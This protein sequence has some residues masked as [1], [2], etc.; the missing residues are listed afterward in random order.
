[1]TKETVVYVTTIEEWK[2]VLNVWF[3]HGYYWIANNKDYSRGRF[4]EYYY[5]AFRD[6]CRQLA[7]S[8]EN[9]VYFYGKNSYKGKTIEYDEFMAQ[10]D[11][12]MAKETYYVTQEQLDLIARA[13]ELYYPLSAVYANLV[14]EFK[15]TDF[16]SLELQKSV[17][18]YLGGDTSIEFKLIEQLYRLWR[19]DTEHDKVYMKFTKTGNPDWTM[20]EDNAFTAT[21]DEIKK[22]KTISWEIEEVNNGKLIK[23]RTNGSV[24]NAQRLGR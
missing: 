2:S 10:N 7:I 21:I 5:E 23:R 8:N 4:K 22:H 12:T 24:G 1:M 16:D 9:V 6:G 11:K 19:I 14:E 17:L 18:R 15:E 3:S 13:K 20:D